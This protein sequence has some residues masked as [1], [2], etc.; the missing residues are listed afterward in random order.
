MQEILE[1]FV[2][3]KICSEKQI[4]QLNRLALIHGIKAI[5]LHG[6]VLDYISK[7]EDKTKINLSIDFPYSYQN[8]SAQLILIKNY[9][10]NYGDLINRINLCVPCNIIQENNRETLKTY[11]KDLTSSKYFNNK[12]IRIVFNC[13]YHKDENEI[14]EIIDLF[15]QHGIDNINLLTTQQKLINN[16]TLLL[17]SEKIKQMSSVNLGIFINTNKIQH[18]KTAQQIKL[19]SVVVLPNNIFKIFDI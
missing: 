12:Q 3:Y 19:D 9:L 10:I 14:I 13:L 2:S 15:Q 11:C 1:I 4:G 5:N 6:H 16:D 8:L 18:I 17:L 7:I